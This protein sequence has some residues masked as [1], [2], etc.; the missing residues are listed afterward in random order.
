MIGLDR[1]VQYLPTLL[2]TLLL[3][4]GLA[5][6]GDTATKQGLSAL[7]TPDQMVDDKVDAVFISLAVHVDYYRINN[8]K[9][10]MRRSHQSRLKPRKASC[11]R[12]QNETV[13]S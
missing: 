11:I 9:I 2:S 12:D 13:L 6:F 1:Q 7:R 3:D 4:E 5:V 8:T 10:N